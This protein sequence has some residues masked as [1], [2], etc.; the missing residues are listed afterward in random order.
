MLFPLLAQ[1]DLKPAAP[2]ALSVEP[3]YALGS[4]LLVS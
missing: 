1:Y 2:F 4:V 3:Q